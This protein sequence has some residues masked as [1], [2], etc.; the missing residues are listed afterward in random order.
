[1]NND[2]TEAIAFMNSALPGPENPANLRQNVIDE[3]PALLGDFYD[4]LLK[5]PAA[6]M[7]AGDKDID[8][9]KTAQA[10]HWTGLF[11]DD[12]DA[13]TL[14]NSKHIGEIHQQAGLPSG[15]YLA[16]YGWV[17]IK[18][19]PLITSQYRFRR[20]EQDAVLCT[21]VGRLFSDMVTSINAYEKSSVKQAVQEIKNTN[22]NNL[23]GIA[24]SIIDVNNMILKLAFLQK[25][26]RDVAGNSQTIS[27]ASTELVSSVEEIARN[28]QT[29]SS[30]SD[31]A[32]ESVSNGRAALEQMTTT[33]GK[34]SDTVDQTSENVNSLAEASDQIGQILTVIED[35]ADQT[36]LLALNATIEAARAG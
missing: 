34:I 24:G 3:L 21:L 15:W 7:F 6:E 2:S 28:S 32:N 35:I 30:E 13:E 9:L 18:L 10:K 36:N 1:M 31:Q 19:I 29:V 20:A 4:T 8:R 25:N 17:L 23:E 5:S 27:S 12:L 14:G 22:T 16:A 33:I 26:S 11:A